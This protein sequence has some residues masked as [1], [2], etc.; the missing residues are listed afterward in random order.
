MVTCGRWIKRPENVSSVVLGKSLKN[1][2]LKSTLEIFS[3]DSV[4][5]SLSSSPLATHVLEEGEPISLAV[6]PNGEDIVCHTTAGDIK[7]FDLSFQEAKTKFLARDL[8]ALQGVGSQR[9]IAFSFDGSRLA[10]GGVDGHLR[11]FEWPS[12]RVVLDE[13]KAHKSFQDMDFSLDSEFLASTSTD[14]SARVWNANEGVLATNLRRK[15]DEKFEL[16]CFSKDGTK[17]FLFCTM[18]KG[19]KSLT[20]VWEMSEWKKIGHKRLM[21]KPA[22]IMC[23]SIDGKYIAFTTKD[24]DLYVVEVTT[25]KIVHRSKR[26]HLGTCIASLDFCPTD[27]VVLTTTTEWSAVIT[28]L[29]VPRDWKDWQ[30]YLVLLGLFLA[31]CV[32]AFY[33][34]Q[35]SDPFWNF[36]TADSGRTTSTFDHT[37]IGDAQTDEWG[38]LE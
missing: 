6:H 5:T 23:S 34:Y 13:P 22:N 17:P 2:S 36:P 38:P 31:S 28:R 26:L 27:R 9:C 11:I 29:T 19:D 21:N 8:P 3:F 24:G 1:S 33:L 20:A 16:C 35:V 18:Q 25:M 7:A 14:G 12:L 4:A 15:A 10:L 37:F 30:I 32:V